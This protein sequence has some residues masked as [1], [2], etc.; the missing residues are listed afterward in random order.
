MIQKSKAKRVL[1]KIEQCFCGSD[2]SHVKHMPFTLKG[3][4]LHRMT[5][6]YESQ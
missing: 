5:Y 4:E 1:Q 2:F 3:S 6:A